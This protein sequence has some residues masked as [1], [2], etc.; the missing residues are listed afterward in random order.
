MEKR[1]M[2]SMIGLVDDHIFEYMLKKFPD[3][4][5]DDI[6]L[7]AILHKE[8]HIKKYINLFG[9]NLDCDFFSN[10]RNV[11]S[12]SAFC[13]DERFKLFTELIFIEK[14]DKEKFISAILNYYSFKD[15][16]DNVIELI[17]V[18]IKE[19]IIDIKNL[20]KKIHINESVEL[21]IKLFESH[22]I[23]KE[24]V[25]NNINYKLLHYSGQDNISVEQRHMLSNFI[26]TNVNEKKF[27]LTLVKNLV[28]SEELNFFS[29]ECIAYLL[30]NYPEI[31]K[32]ESER[33]VSIFDQKKIYKAL[34]LIDNVNLE[35][36]SNNNIFENA[37]MTME[38][39][40]NDETLELVMNFK[41]KGGDLS[42]I[43]SK[44]ES[45]ITTLAKKNAVVIMNL[46]NNNILSQ[47][48]I[49]SICIKKDETQEKN[50]FALC[51]LEEML[52]KYENNKLKGEIS[53]N[54][55]NKEKRI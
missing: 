4:K 55:K 29:E 36:P 14:E 11:M 53:G 8:E 22:T 52:I 42:A 41:K 21:L 23:E 46:I 24:C 15:L 27:I 2:L 20:C 49:E 50:K 45:N 37:L 34:I 9:R 40:Y 5:I 54:Y 32:I 44:K 33:V 43:N 10:V 1:E 18:L 12:I 17:S 48:E 13:S 6:S 38:F 26:L 51:I 35:S 3:G 7:L 16:S 25:L 47:K 19:K 30:N 31:A 39:C 28:K